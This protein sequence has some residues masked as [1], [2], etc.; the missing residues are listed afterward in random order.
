MYHESVTMNDKIKVERKRIL[1][2]GKEQDLSKSND[3]FLNDKFEIYLN[4]VKRLESEE[5]GWMGL[6]FY[7][8]YMGEWKED[9]IAKKAA[10]C[11]DILQLNFVLHTYM[12]Y[13]PNLNH[14][15]RIVQVVNRYL[16]CKSG[17]IKSDEDDSILRGILTCICDYILIIVNQYLDKNHEFNDI[18]QNIL[19]WYVETQVRLYQNFTNSFCDSYEEITEGKSSYCLGVYCRKGELDIGPG[20]H[21]NVLKELEYS[22]LRKVVGCDVEVNDKIRKIPEGELKKLL[23]SIEIRIGGV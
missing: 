4:I 7:Y 5:E 11:I 3:N 15:D 16:P 9:E 2:N 1:D 17:L 20:E 23:D 13:S 6:L 19:H 10:A 21:D 12:M 18:R 8:G 22:F 14:A